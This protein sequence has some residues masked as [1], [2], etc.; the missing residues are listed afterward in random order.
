MRTWIYTYKT[1]DGLRHE[2]EMSASSKD[3]VYAALRAR[4]IRAIRVTER[5]VPVVRRGFRGLRKRDWL[6]IASGVLVIAVVIAI[7]AFRH[8]DGVRP[9]Y[10]RQAQSKKPYVRP[11]EEFVRLEAAAGMVMSAFRSAYSKIDFALLSNYALV[12]RL[13]DVTE[14]RVEIERGRKVA[15]QSKESVRAVYRRLYAHI[16][17]ARIDDRE[18]AQKLYGEMIGEIESAEEAFDGD[19]CALELL[20][21]NR[22]KWK[23]VRGEVQWQDDKL[24]R[25]FGFF[26]RSTAETVSRWTKDFGGA[27]E[28]NRKNVIGQRA[29][30]MPPL[31]DKLRDYEK[32]KNPM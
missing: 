25:E 20:C 26:R 19:E 11:S 24:A 3:E 18:T 31:S 10:A 4:G 30:R 29:G 27:S 13:P 22:G 9:D 23:I 5:I 16:P 2:D 21:R 15:A 12:E 28:L 17:E 32:M 1:S 14:F 6:L 8:G 7:A